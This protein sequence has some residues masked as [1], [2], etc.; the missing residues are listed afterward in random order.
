[1]DLKN[2]RSFC[3]DREEDLYVGPILWSEFMLH[4]VSTPES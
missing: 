2:R 3:L 1:M 4:Q